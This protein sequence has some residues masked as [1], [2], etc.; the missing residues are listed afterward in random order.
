MKNYKRKRTRKKKPKQV[1]VR[2]LE[3]YWKNRKQN[4]K[5]KFIY[6]SMPALRL[7]EDCLEK[8]GQKK[9][10]KIKSENAE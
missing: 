6:P 4:I 3:F 2:E 1:M 10:K 8:N 9:K 5:A 7:S